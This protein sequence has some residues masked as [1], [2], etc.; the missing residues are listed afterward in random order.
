MGTTDARIDQYIAKA[1]PFARPILEYLRD[2]VHAGCPDCE[3]TLKWSMAEGKPRN[4][5][6]LTPTKTPAPAPR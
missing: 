3:E 5:K 6:Y 2:A 1:Q 4:W